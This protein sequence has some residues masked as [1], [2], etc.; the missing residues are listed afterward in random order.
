MKNLIAPALLLAALAVPASRAHAQQAPD[1]IEGCEGVNCGCFEDYRQA[2]SS[3]GAPLDSDIKA[4]KA[5]T[6]YTDHDLKSPVL[7]KFEAGTMARPLQQVIVFVTKGK[8]TVESAK[9]QN[10][11]LKAGDTVDDMIDDGEGLRRVN[12]KGKWLGFDSTE[13]DVVLKTGTKT[14]TADWTQVQVDGKTGYTLDAPFA[15]CGVN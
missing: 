2:G 13:K 3:D 7:G 11:G 4:A 14:Q 12:F 8:Y 5:F 10:L 1:S 6:L 9:S 15:M